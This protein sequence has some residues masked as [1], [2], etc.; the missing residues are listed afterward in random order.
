MAKSRDF[1]ICGHSRDLHDRDEF[2]MRNGR[3]L[4]PILVAGVFVE[5][6]VPLCKCPK[7]ERPATPTRRVA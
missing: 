2:G 3:C 4:K 7:F 1:C 5:H 6:P